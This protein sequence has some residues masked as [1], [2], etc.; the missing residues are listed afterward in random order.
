MA[1]AAR[2]HA[3]PPAYAALVVATTLALV[4]GIAQACGAP[5]P[6]SVMD[7]PRAVTPDRNLELALL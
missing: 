7:A 6:A 2:Q 3:P 4:L 5:P 1:I